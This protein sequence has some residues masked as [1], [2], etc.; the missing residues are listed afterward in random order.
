MKKE[1]EDMARELAL[2]IFPLYGLHKFTVHAVLNI[3]KPKTIRNFTTLGEML[4]V[5]YKRGEAAA[6]A[7]AE[8]EK[9]FTGADE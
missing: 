2:S 8:L 1:D 5:A 4:L 9:P 3:E 6:H 7:V